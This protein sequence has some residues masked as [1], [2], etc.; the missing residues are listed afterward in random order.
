MGCSGILGKKNLVRNLY[1]KLKI[2]HNGLERR[3][4]E[5]TKYNL[6]KNLVI[7]TKPDLVINCSA[8]I[9]LDYCESNKLKSKKI[10]VGILKNLFF[11]RKVYNL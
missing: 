1:Y 3:K 7:K 2:L 11:I 4:F 8:A 6:L 9:D 10:N 5:L